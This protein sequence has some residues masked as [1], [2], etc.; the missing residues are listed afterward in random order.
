[1]ADIANAT[2]G[3]TTIK[4]GTLVVSCLKTGLYK[5]DDTYVSNKP[6]LSS[7][8]TK[9]SDKFDDIIYYSDG[10]QGT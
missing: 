9:Y 5:I 1:M 10:T 8:E 6:E 3:T 7:I 2:T 4:N